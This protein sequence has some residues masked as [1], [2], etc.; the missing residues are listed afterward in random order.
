MCDCIR[1]SLAETPFIVRAWPMDASQ[2]Y[3]DQSYWVTVDLALENAIAVAKGE[4]H[5]QKYR[6]VMVLDIWSTLW[7]TIGMLWAIEEKKT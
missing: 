3:V 6:Q 5:G 1:H 7:A 2:P 4:F